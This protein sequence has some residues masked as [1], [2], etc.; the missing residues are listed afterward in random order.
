MSLGSGLSLSKALVTALV[1]IQISSR[2][3][4]NKT[5]YLPSSLSIEAE[6]LID[7]TSC[8]FFDEGTTV[9]ADIVTSNDGRLASCNEITNALSYS[10]ANSGLSPRAVGP[11]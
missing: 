7:M 2:V 4:E 6:W 8:D 10:S 1:D 5:R 11:S 9:I 3:K